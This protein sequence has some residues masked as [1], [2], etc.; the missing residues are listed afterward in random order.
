M[1]IYAYKAK[2]GP[3]RT[4]Q[5][6]V[7]AAS[8]AGAVAAIDDLGYSPVWVREKRVAKGRRGSL[9]RRVRERDVTVFT[10]QL[11][12]LTRSGVPILRALSTIRDQTE[13]ARLAAIVGRLEATIR[14]GSMLSG[15][16]GRYPKLFPE[17]Y[18]NMV[19]SGE[20]AGVLDRVL[21]RLAEARDKEEDIRRKVR[22]A[23]AYPALVLGVGG[24]TVFALLSFFLPRVMELFEDYRELPL[25]T[26]I[27]VE[28][29]RFFEESWYWVL[30]VLALV[31]AV[32]SRLSSFAAG[33]AA[34]DSAKLRLPVLGRAVLYAEIARFARTFSL[35]LEAGIPV[36]SSLSLSADTLNNT[37]LRAEVEAVK[38]ETVEQG[39]PISGGL[40]R[41]RLF[42]AFV[43]NMV[44]VGE[45]A[46]R[47][48]ESLTEVALF[49]EKEVDVQSRLLTS[50]LEPILILV[51]G[52]LVGFIVAAMLLPIFEIGTSF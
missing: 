34:L 52:A 31:L 18:V 36:E 26:R 50:L 10:N 39:A 17:L 44:A 9:A 4:V 12:S 48:D 25:P 22:A 7:D 8:R 51:V 23:L 16:M 13:N 28:I 15:A 46:G 24:V 19:R 14:D 21:T 40:K 47:L 42:P 3:G 45:E 41:S 43:A 37:A 27:L 11:A 33:R 32:L 49:Y 6:E 2:D 30:L 5:G 1:S 35:L 29:S 20:S 38:K